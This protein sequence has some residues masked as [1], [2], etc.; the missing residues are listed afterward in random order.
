MPE[1]AS[2]TGAIFSP[3]QG[4]RI[5]VVEDELLLV[6][7]MRDELEGEGAQVVGPAN[8]VREALDLLSPEAAPDAAILDVSLQGEMVYPVADALLARG[9]P[10]VF[11]TGYEA[12]VI[13][14]AYTCIP[15]IDKPV[16]MQSL[17]QVLA[18]ELKVGRQDQGRTIC[19]D[20]GCDDALSVGRL[21]PP[22]RSS[23]SNFL[24]AWW[25]QWW[26]RPQR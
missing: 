21:R 9:I 7:E 25:S 8:S 4:S 20:E 3:V 22:Q 19:A 24:L 23:S 12:R 1:I 14:L 5:L 6:D 18:T 17:L 10:F 13:P 11:V 15:R 26:D 2:S 16:R